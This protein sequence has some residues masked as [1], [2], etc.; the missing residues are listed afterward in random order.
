LGRNVLVCPYKR[1]F[2]RLLDAVLRLSVTPA[3]DGGGPATSLALA[4]RA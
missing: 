3:G 4:R 1:L 2:L